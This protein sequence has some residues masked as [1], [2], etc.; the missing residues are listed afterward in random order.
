MSEVVVKLN[1]TLDIYEYGSWS[2]T[3]YFKQTRRFWKETP[4]KLEKQGISMRFACA[5]DS[6]FD[7]HK[8]GNWVRAHVR[9]M[10]IE[11]FKNGVDYTVNSS[12]GY[13]THS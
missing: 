6:D 5:D 12:R 3:K 4:K 10:T 1:A 8:S 9:I 11:Q 13:Q 7:D 2:S